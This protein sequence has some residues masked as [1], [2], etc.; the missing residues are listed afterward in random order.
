MKTTLGLRKKSKQRGRA[1]HPISVY[2]PLE[3]REKLKVLAKENRRDLSSQC[4][5]LLEKVLVT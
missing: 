3:L 5:F 2:V 1:V 4:I